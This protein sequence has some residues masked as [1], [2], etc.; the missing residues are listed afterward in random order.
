MLDHLISANQS[1]QDHLQKNNLDKKDIDFI[2]ELIMGKHLKTY[3][4]FTLKHSSISKSWKCRGRD[5]KKRFLYEVCCLNSLL[6]LNL[7]K[8]IVA[9][10]RTSVDVD[11]WDYFARDCHCL[12]ISNNFD[13]K[14]YVTFA[15]VIEVN[16][17]RQICC[18]DKV[19]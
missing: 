16:G 8:Q 7:F 10:K 12:G 14:R 3:S 15:R 18:R 11:K 19:N 4:E 1:V 13:W 6:P 9:N 2:K 5:E 17:Q